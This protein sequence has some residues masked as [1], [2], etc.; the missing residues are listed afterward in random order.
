MIEAYVEDML[1]EP[2]REAFRNHL[3]SCIHCRRAALQEDPTLL[4]GANFSFAPNEERVERCTQAVVSEIRQDRLKQRLGTRRRRWLAAAAAVLV[5][6][7]GGA[8]WRIADHYGEM[9]P[10]EVAEASRPEH[11]SPPP[12]VEVDMTGDGV[13]VYQFAEEDDGDSAVY[14]IV[15]PAL[16][17]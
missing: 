8:V 14:F 11:A 1:E 9:T 12:R 5:A 10:S 4:F 6:I 16:E 2:Q 13:R 15:N 17:L 7:V 3:G